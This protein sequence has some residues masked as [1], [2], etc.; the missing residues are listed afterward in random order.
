MWQSEPTRQSYTAA[1]SPGRMLPSQTERTADRVADL[2]LAATKLQASLV[3]LA[4]ASQRRLQLAAAKGFGTA[5]ECTCEG[6]KDPSIA[7]AL[8]GEFTSCYDFAGVSQPPGCWAARREGVAT[9]LVLPL[10]TGERPLAV[11]QILGEARPELSQQQAAAL[12]DLAAMAALALENA[13]RYDQASALFELSKTLSTTLD[14]VQV[15][16]LIAEHVA[17]AIGAKGCTVRS[18]DRIARRLDLVGA[19]GLSRKYLHDKGPVLAGQS[20]ADA[21]E[22]KPTAIF[23]V[24][25]DPRVQY[26]QAA[27]EEGISSIASIPM[28]VKGVVTGVL[29]VYTAQPHEFSPEEMAF[30]CAAAGVAGAALENAR[31]YDGIR[32]DFEI[33]MDEIVFMRRAARAVGGSKEP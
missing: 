9:R 20:I 1:W 17:K 4:D 32:H 13:Q 25:E 15:G 12:C 28:V 5:N 33:L 30:L 10:Q 3:C 11:L 24:A 31:L 16:N 14:M 27:V 19:Y 6:S 26:P 21:L 8:R 18:L 23:N 7:T 2:T 29:R 22:G